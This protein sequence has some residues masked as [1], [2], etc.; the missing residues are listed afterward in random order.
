MAETNRIEVRKLQEGAVRIE[1]KLD[2]ALIGLEGCF[3]APK[4]CMSDYL[5]FQSNEDV[6]GFLRE[7]SNIERKKKF[8][9][10]VKWADMFL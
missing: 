6:L 8:L 1:Q 9:T 2:T 5:P 3:T 4:L 10:M 7:D